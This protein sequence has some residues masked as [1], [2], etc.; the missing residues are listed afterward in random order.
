MA[1]IFTL[2]ISQRFAQDLEN[3]RRVAGISTLE[4]LLVDLVEVGVADFRLRKITTPTLGGTTSMPE[5]RWTHKRAELPEVIM[6][7]ENLRFTLTYQQIAKRLGISESSVR[8]IIN[9][10]R[11]REED[12]RLA[13]GK[14]RGMKNL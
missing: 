3:M 1:A 9:S 14:M 13:R 7:V 8:R 12:A 4:S 6:R 2:K 10:A 5:V 11:I